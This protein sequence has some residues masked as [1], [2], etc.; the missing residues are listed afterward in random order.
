[1]FHSPWLLSTLG[2]HMLRQNMDVLDQFSKSFFYYHCRY[3]YFKK[4]VSIL[5]LL[6][7]NP[8]SIIYALP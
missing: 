6:T 3:L 5:K 1:M 7:S 4:L 8:L 2:A